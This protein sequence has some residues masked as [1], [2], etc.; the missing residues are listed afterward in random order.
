[1]KATDIEPGRAYILQV[2]I[3]PGP[4]TPRFKTRQTATVIAVDNARA[5][6]VEVLE[7]VCVNLDEIPPDGIAAAMIN[8]QLRY[9]LRPTKRIVKAADILA[10]AQP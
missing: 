4:R 10:E 3:P 9:Q 8:G 6:T 5:V 2:I 1:M 7:P